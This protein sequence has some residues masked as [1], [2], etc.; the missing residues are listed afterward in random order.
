MVGC[1]HGHND[2]MLVAAGSGLAEHATPS[3]AGVPGSFAEKTIAI[4]YNDSDALK[5]VFERYPGQIAGV[6]VEPVA[7]NM[8][9]ILPKTDYLKNLR[10]LCDENETVLIFDEVITGFRVSFGGAQQLYGIRS[11]LTCLGKIIGGGLPLAAIG[12]KTEIMDVLAPEGPV[13]QAGTLSG[14]P[15]AVAAANTTLDLLQDE[16]VYQKLEESGKIL[17]DSFIEASKKLSIPVTINRVGSILSCFFT[18]KPVFNFDDVSNTDIA[19]FKKFFS[20]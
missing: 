1:Y 4:D 2:S 20:I 16:T 9:V 19:M 8:G 10:R 11:D 15:V 12:G 6:I 7:A 5:A 3:S 14:N 13:Y 17:Q 18:E